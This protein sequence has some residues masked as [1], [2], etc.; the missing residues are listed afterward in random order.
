MINH[1]EEVLRALPNFPTLLS[2]MLVS[3]FNE[4]FSS[5]HKMVLTE[6][7]RKDLDCRGALKD[8]FG[9][10]FNE[11]SRLLR[12]CPSQSNVIYE[13]TGKLAIELQSLITRH[14]CLPNDSSVTTEDLALF[15]TSVLA[16]NGAAGCPPTTL[17]SSIVPSIPVSHISEGETEN[18]LNSPISSSLRQSDQ[19]ETLTRQEQSLDESSIPCSRSLHT[20]SEPFQSEACQSSISQ[21]Q[22]AQTVPTQLKERLERQEAGDERSSDESIDDTIERSDRDQ[23]EMSATVK[24]TRPTARNA[25]TSINQLAPT[26]S[27]SSRVKIV[28]RK[29]TISAETPQKIAKQHSIQQSDLTFLKELSPIPKESKQPQE[30]YQIFS[31]RCK[32]ESYDTI[33]LL[34]RLFFAVA[35]PAAFYQL[36]DACTASRRDEMQGAPRPTTD[37]LQTL[38]ALDQ[39]DVHVSTAS[40]LRRYHLTYLAACRHEKEEHIQSG[41]RR[42]PRQL[43]YGV[44]MTQTQRVATGNGNDGSSALAAM[45]KEAYPSLAKKTDEYQKMYQLLVQRMRRGRNW[46]RLQRRLSPGILALVPTGGELD[47]HNS[48]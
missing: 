32:D 31:S 46:Y 22:T 8:L 18:T 29:S 41:K 21:L 25:F 42:V 12:D 20:R 39:L 44:S 34:T 1:D 19:F 7:A 6:N 17:Q 40:I 3:F 47:I 14:K 43:K 11:V 38:Q 28:K 33:S 24:R 26:L 13:E 10:V 48:E 5:N 30:V 37:V 9:H 15:V 2:L 16:L 27:P 35:S 23:L 4:C 36:R 45:M